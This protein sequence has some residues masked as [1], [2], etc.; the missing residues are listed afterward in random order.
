MSPGLTS[1]STAT[2]EESALSPFVLPV[3]GTP[4]NHFN[5]SKPYEPSFHV[6]NTV[7]DQPPLFRSADKPTTQ[8]PPH[9]PAKLRKPRKEGYESDGGYASDAGKKKKKEKKRT[10]KDKGDAGDDTDHDG[11]TSAIDNAKP[12]PKSSRKTKAASPPDSGDVSDAGYLSESSVKKKR[13][14]FRL[15]KTLKKSGSKD[16]SQPIPPVPA[17]PP[18]LM[19]LPIAE[20]W[21]SEAPS[22]VIDTS[23]RS[24]T[25][26]PGLMR[27]FGGH[28]GS[29][30]SSSSMA[31]TFTASESNNSLTLS[32]IRANTPDTQN[33]PDRTKGPAPRVHFTLSTQFP[34]RSGEVDTPVSPPRLIISLPITS[35]G[36]S[37]SSGASS[38]QPILVRPT[39]NIKKA[40]TPLV[41]SSPN[42]LNPESPSPVPS[43]YI[44]VPSAEFVVPSPSRSRRSPL[45]SPRGHFAQY[46]LPPP[47]PPPQGPLPQ[48]PVDQPAFDVRAPPSSFMQ[49]SSINRSNAPSPSPSLFA[50]PIPLIQ[51]GRESPFPTRPVLPQAE[52][53]ELVRRT[54]ITQRA[55]MMATRA[56]AEDDS[57]VGAGAD[58]RSRRRV[59]FLQ[60]ETG[61][62]SEDGRAASALG[63]RG[64]AAFVTPEITVADEDDGPTPVS[65]GADEDDV[66]PDIAA[67]FFGSQDAGQN[68]ATAAAM[69]ASTV[70]GTEDGRSSYIDDDRSLYP[71]DTRTLE[72]N[73][74]RATIDS[75]YFHADGSRESVWSKRASFLDDERSGEVRERFVRGVA[76]MYS[77]DGRE[78]EAI[79]PVPKLPF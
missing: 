34:K 14:F 15:N 44:I 22:L 41:L 48:I 10:K 53:T 13:S 17:M 40:P 50:Q 74:D 66:R 8:I 69:R 1:A 76:A 25:P 24:V 3:T 19:P 64:A 47:S 5:G 7:A 6:E 60:P 39:P 70:Y 11:Y 75:Y 27:N 78:R 57:G 68:M 56:F 35:S 30:G 28:S 52:S 33:S 20:K 21:A 59:Q 49:G 73:R 26:I 23:S 63:V 71:D 31:E 43:D 45:P 61:L 77:G 79:P 38:P 55:R 58:G 72:T 2:S 4:P 9:R 51:R 42:F 12:S 67:F 18:M 32:S 54:S 46:D 36:S 65:R 16:L 29:I 37:S 62:D